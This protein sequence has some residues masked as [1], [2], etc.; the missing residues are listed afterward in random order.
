MAS[1]APS[2]A[3][4]TPTTP[5]PRDRTPRVSLLALVAFSCSVLSCPLVLGTFWNTL[6]R[7]I[8]WERLPATVDVLL[9][10]PLWVGCAGAVASLRIAL[11]EGRLRGRRLALF[12]FWHAAAWLV[13][14][15]FAWQVFKDS[16]PHC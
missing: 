4:A 14:T 9:W 7:W 8:A 6:D 3:Y 1:A 12:A 16:G 10:T 2:L 11:S 15:Y 5:A 13:F